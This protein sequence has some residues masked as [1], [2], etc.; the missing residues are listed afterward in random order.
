[1]SAV[2][3]SVVIAG[4]ATWHTMH[5]EARAVLDTGPAVVGHGLI[6]S[7][8]VLTR[9]PAPHRAEGEIVSAFLADAFPGAPLTLDAQRL[10]RFVLDLADSG[11]SGG[12]VYDALIATT[13]QATDHVLVTCDVRAAE[14]YGRVGCEARLLA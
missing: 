4:F 9:L 2:D 10:R 5:R 3:S 14:T 12:A 1:M 8:S 7:Y 11:V 6:E 13:A